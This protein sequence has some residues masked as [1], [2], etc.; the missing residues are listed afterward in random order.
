VLKPR[1]GYLLAEA[2]CALALAGALAATAATAL[3][4][5]QRA[6]RSGE[7]R[8]RAGR[9]ERET[10]AVLRAALEGGHVIAVRGDTAVDIDLAIAL[11]PACG[12]E[13]RAVLL[14]PVV[15][16]S[17]SPLTSAMQS[18]GPDDIAAIRLAAGPRD[19]PTWVE[20]V[21]DSVQSRAVVGLCDASDGWAGAADAASPRWRVTFLDS[22]P[23]ELEPGTT[24][25]IG[26]PG[27]F[28][29]YHAGGGDWMLG[30]RRCSADFAVCGVVQPVAG[31]LRTPSAGGLR[32]RELASP[33]R[34]EIEARGA[35]SRQE[36]S[37]ATVYR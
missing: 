35:G 4:A 12:V 19:A 10:V 14:P 5:A 27:R 9:A 26:R 29:L 23:V 37:R 22:L 11:G 3:T 21:V 28:T 8:E 32:I 7:E 2:L 13:P 30:W 31:P 33:A 16:A 25:R 18:P 6:R 20:Y 15:V 24:V 34:W 17:G 1:R 36:V